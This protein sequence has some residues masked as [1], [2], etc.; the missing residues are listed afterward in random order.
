MALKLQKVYETSFLTK[1]K[2][3]KIISIMRENTPLDLDYEKMPVIKLWWKKDYAKFIFSNYEKDF[4]IPQF[5]SKNIVDIKDYTFED[6][7]SLIEKCTLVQIYEKDNDLK[8]DNY[9]NN[10]NIEKY[11]DYSQTITD[12]EK[13][14]FVCTIPS[15]NIMSLDGRKFIILSK[16]NEKIKVPNNYMEEFYEVDLLGTSLFTDITEYIENLWSNIN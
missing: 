2:Y 15:K 1:E 16:S 6:F 10:V 4:L 14:N 12:L 13:E 5:Y 8:L 9:F 7:Y 11:K 3:D